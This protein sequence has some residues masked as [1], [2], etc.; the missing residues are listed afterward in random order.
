ME[1]VLSYV[2]SPTQPLTERVAIVVGGC[3]VLI[4]GLFAAYSI[5]SKGYSILSAKPLAH[6]PIDLSVIDTLG[7]DLDEEATVD[8]NLIDKGYGLRIPTE[9]FTL[10]QAATEVIT[11]INEAIVEKSKTNPQASIQEKHSIL[12]TANRPYMKNGS[13]LF[14]YKEFCGDLSS[15]IT[16]NSE[17]V[18]NFWL[19]RIIKALVDK[20]HIQLTNWNGHGYF[21]QT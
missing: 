10:G 19:N 17:K 8:A 1:A 3:L 7:L 15:S 5:I 14:Y 9:T 2:L 13:N 21:I 6:Q 16:L 12:L 4:G 20:K 11:K 18:R